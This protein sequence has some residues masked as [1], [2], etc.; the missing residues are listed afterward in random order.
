MQIVNNIAKRL[1]DV[2]HTNAILTTFN[3]INMYALINIKK[4]YQELFK[5]SYNLN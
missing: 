1:I 5:K 2:Q 3:E 4:K